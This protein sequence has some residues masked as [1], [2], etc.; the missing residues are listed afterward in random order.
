MSL[1]VGLLNV[2][3]QKVSGTNDLKCDP[4]TKSPDNVREKVTVSNCR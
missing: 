2:S 1:K 3:T 4:S